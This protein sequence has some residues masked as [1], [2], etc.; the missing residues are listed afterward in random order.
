MEQR[1]RAI[2]VTRGAEYNAVGRGLRRANES[3][4]EVLPLPIGSRAVYPHLESLNLTREKYPAVLVMGLCGSLKPDHGLGDPVFY[5]GCT[6]RVEPSSVRFLSCAA[7]LNIDVAK[8]LGKPVPLIKGL[9]SD[10]I[11]WSAYEKR[12]LGKEYDT[13]VVDMEGFGILQALKSTGIDVAMMRVVS[14]DCH[15]DIP[16]LNGAIGPDGSLRPLPLALGMIR[17]PAR[18]ANLIQG[19]LQGLRALQAITTLLFTQN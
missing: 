9:T 12:E 17:Q 1:I 11:I 4:V 16:D 3:T 6:Y 7:Q 2:L 10:R 13:G 14:D 5:E 18:A 8:R 19:S 15:R